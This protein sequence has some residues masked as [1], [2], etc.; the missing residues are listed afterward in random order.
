M[1]KLALVL[2]LSAA[3][4]GCVSLGKDPPP[5][6]LT[7][8]PAVT[9]PAGLSAT[10]KPID[11]LTVIEPAAPQKL[12]VTRVPVQ[13]DGATIAYLKD[14]VWVEKP[15]RLFARLI[16]ETIRA[17][18][19]RMVIEG[20]DVRFAAATK[21]SGQ[22]TEM[23]YDVQSGSV[24]VRFDAVLQQPNGQVMTRR[25][26]ATVPGVQATPEAVGPALNQAANKVAADVAAWI[27]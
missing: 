26:E 27:G 15:A 22:L 24:V 20:S 25:F 11:A 1:K 18:Q 3:L 19:T 23:G 10:G 4:S 5:A 13:V 17:K 9:A 12:D 2:T 6:L 16:S 14:A 7:L 21:L 8:T